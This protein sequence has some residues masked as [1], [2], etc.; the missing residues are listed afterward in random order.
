MDMATNIV[1]YTVDPE[2]AE[3]LHSRVREH[4]VPAARQTQGYRGFLLLDRGEGKRLAILLFDSAAD[5]RA[6]QETLAP[7]GI[8]H[9]AALMQGPIQRAV[10]AVVIGDGVFAEAVAR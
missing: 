4:L 3:T 7:V 1:E 5:A 6:A 8:E 10:G 9:T 2:Q